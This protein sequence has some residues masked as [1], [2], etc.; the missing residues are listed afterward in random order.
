MSLAAKVPTA[1][2]FS[3]PDGKSHETAS[4]N[5]NAPIYNRRM[6]SDRREAT[7]AEPSPCA[8]GPRQSL[9]ALTRMNRR[10]SRFVLGWRTGLSRALLILQAG[11]ALNFFGY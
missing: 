3:A 1:D 8:C 9:E 10:V 5:C 6:W 4:P 7:L 11:N 2:D